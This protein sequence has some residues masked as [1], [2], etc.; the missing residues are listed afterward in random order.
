METFCEAFEKGKGKIL[1]LILMLAL[2][3]LWPAL[4]RSADSGDL[5]KRAQQGDASAQNE[6]GDA[7]YYGKAVSQDY[8]KAV[9]WYRKAAE[10]GF[11]PAQF[12]AATFR[13]RALGA[14]QDLAAAAR[15]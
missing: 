11:A 13:A 8:K 10:Q 1:G 5:E 14:P 9:E 7:L 4:S 3:S 2:I 6:M 15:W 12:K